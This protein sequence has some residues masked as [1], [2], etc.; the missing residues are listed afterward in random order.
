M[1]QNNY[2]NNLTNCQNYWV[3]NNQETYTDFIPE[4][5]NV[6]TLNVYFPHYSLETY[7]K[8]IFYTLS[9]KIW[10]DECEVTIGSFLLNRLNTVASDKPVKFLNQSYYEKLEFT[11][12]DPYYIIYSDEWKL[13]RLYNIYK[14]VELFTL[15]GVELQ[16]FINNYKEPNDNSSNILLQFHPVEKIDGKYVKLT[17]YQGGQNTIKFTNEEDQFL[18]LKLT[19][20]FN[21][22]NKSPEIYSELIFNKLY[23]KNISKYLNET[24]NIYNYN[25][26][27]ELVVKDD[28]NIYKYISR[29]GKENIYSFGIDDFCFES[30]NEYVPGMIFYAIATIQNIDEFGNVYDMLELRSNEIIITQ[31]IFKFLIKKEKLSINNI[32]LNTVDMINYKC[33]IVNKIQKNIIQV[34]RPSDYKNNI[35]KPVFFRTSQVD[36]LQLHTTVIENIAINLDSYKNKVEIFY[37]NIN[38]VLFQ[39][40]GRNNS[41]V[42]FKI[43]GNKLDKSVKSGNYYILNQDQEMVTYGNYTLIL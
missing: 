42:I 5:V 23:D 8:N 21:I 1:F 9:L 28:A 6:S 33:N 38:G 10:I 40:I 4:F 11:L 15:T 14:P 36:D 41:G 19:H 26:N 20:N 31:E 35:I 3:N 25:I 27:V 29:S 24:Y 2:Y 39:E 34:D 17:T 7:E 16:D 43:I 32:N 18:N 30:W 22:S 12:P 13:W 37:L